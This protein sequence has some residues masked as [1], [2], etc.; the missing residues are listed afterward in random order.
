MSRDDQIDVYYSIESY[1][2]RK[3]NEANV[4]SLTLGG[5]AINTIKFRTA[6]NAEMMMRKIKAKE[7]KADYTYIMLYV[8]KHDPDLKTEEIV[9]EREIEYAD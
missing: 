8:I 3:N 2:L 6:G 9:A 4:N 1:A 5:Q 7:V